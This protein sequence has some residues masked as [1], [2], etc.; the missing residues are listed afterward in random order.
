LYIEPLFVVVKVIGLLGSSGVNNFVR[1]GPVNDV[2]S[3]WGCLESNCLFR[4]FSNRWKLIRSTSK[5]LNNFVLGEPKVSS[6]SFWL[7]YCYLQ[8]W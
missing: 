7:C 6:V 3:H 8:N 2:V 1:D 5:D 4:L